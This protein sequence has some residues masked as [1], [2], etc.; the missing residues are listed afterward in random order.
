MSRALVNFLLDTLLLM[1]FAMLVWSGVIVRF[2]FPPGTDAKGWYL[3]GLGYDQWA[4]VQD[5]GSA[6]L[7]IHT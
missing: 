7:G 4:T 5:G 2:V 3:W 1:A 6:A